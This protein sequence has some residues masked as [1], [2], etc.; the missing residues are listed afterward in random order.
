MSASPWVAGSGSEAGGVVPGVTLLDALCTAIGDRS[1]TG[2]AAALNRLISTGRLVP[3]DRLPTVRVLAAALGTSPATVAE[4][5]R[6]LNAAGAIVPRGRAGTFVSV[7]ANSARRYHQMA[8][9][10]PEALALDLSTGV[11]DP[12][13][14]PEL[15]PAAMHVASR[16]VTTNYIDA[17][18]LPELEE[19]LLATWPYPVPAL[20]VVDGALDAIDRLLRQVVRLGDH[21]VVEQ[22][23][24][25]PFLDM[26]E[27]LGAVVV[28]VDVD[29]SGLSPSGLA[30]ALCAEPVAVLLQPRA[31]NPTGASM[32]PSR[33]RAL[34]RVVRAAN[35][36]RLL[37]LED[38]HSGSIAGADETSLGALLPDQVVHVRSYS[39]SHGPDLRIAAVGGPAA[40]VNELIAARQ[41]GPGWTSRF[42]QGVLLYLLTDPASVASVDAARDRYAQRRRAM[43]AALA[44]HGIVVPPGE[45]LSMWL[46]VADERSAVITLAA[47]GIGVSPGG[48]FCVRSERVRRIRVT[49]GRLPDDTGAIAEVAR[50][51]ALAADLRAGRTG[52]LRQVAPA[53]ARR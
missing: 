35:L 50:L 18:V 34:A 30:D 22:P 12:D 33:V 29:R 41:L 25:P 38:D 14:L 32:T 46:P 19:R 10:G 15:A 27:R 5:W 21:V 4:A 43:S 16:A 42:L 24:F 23:C 26:L 8:A 6:A 20:T 17:P 45:G 1:A 7:P 31:H 2:I 53:T 52:S 51:L 39:K 28:P 3:G 9:A 37:L 48:P 40:V 49:L 11:P 44:E 13:L 36:P 47:A